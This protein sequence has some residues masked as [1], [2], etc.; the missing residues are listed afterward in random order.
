MYTFISI[1]KYFIIA[2]LAAGVEMLFVKELLTHVLGK[3]CF[4]AYIFL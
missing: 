4:N 3:I 1:I 2:V